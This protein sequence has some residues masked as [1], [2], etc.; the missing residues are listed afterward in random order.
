MT[1]VQDAE[2]ESVADSNGMARSVSVTIA[3]IVIPV[4]AAA[5]AILYLFPTRTESLW[6]WEIGTR[7]TPITM[8]AGYLGGVWFFMRVIATRQPHRHRGGFLG[9]TALTTGLGLATL[10]HWDAFSHGHLSFWAW[11]FLYLAGPFAFAVLFVALHRATPPPSPDEERL[12]A[13]LRGA[14]VTIGVV[15]ATVAIAIFVVPSLVIDHWPWPMTPLTVRSI[16]PF[17]GFT[18]VF[19]LWAWVDARYSAL[20]IGVEATT[21]GL[22]LIAIGALTALGDFSGP[23]G[24]QVAYVGALIGLLGVLVVFLATDPARSDRRLLVR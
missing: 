5:W 14:L 24:S 4:L 13:W 2:Q 6:A 11:S 21:I 10:L 9:I 15:Q 3:A 18:G 20:R 17:I 22:G 12:P 19:A 7:M 23:T 8:G 1:G 16:A